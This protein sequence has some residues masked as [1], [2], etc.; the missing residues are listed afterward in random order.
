VRR[1]DKV[2]VF[3]VLVLLA[4]GCANDDE[5]GEQG[6]SSTS[7][8][9]TAVVAVAGPP[10]LEDRECDPDQVA[11]VPA[12]VVVECSW[13]VVPARRDDPGAGEFRLAVSVLRS[14][15]DA[16]APDPVVYVSG[17]PGMPGG[18]PLSWA[19]R[20]WVQERDVVL[21]DQRGTGASEPDLEC[22]EAEPVY[23]EFFT[24]DR[25]YDEDAAALREALVACRDRLVA[26]GIDLAVFNTPES[27]ADLADLRVALGYDEWNLYGV[28]YGSR[29][30]LEVMRSHPEGIRSV[31]LD[32][33][34][35]MGNGTVTWTVESTEHAFGQ[36]AAGCAADP[37]CAAE[38]EDLRAELDAVVERYNETPHRSVVDLG[39]NDGGPT[40]IVIT[41][42]DIQA[43]MYEAIFGNQLIP[44]LPS[45]ITALN[46][47]E[48][49]LLDQ[50]AVQSIPAQGQGAEAMRY[51]T[52]CADTAPLREADS[53]ADSEVLEQPGS[54]ST[55]IL[56]V[57]WAFCD[58]W[59]AGAVDDSFLDP[60]DADLPVLVL[61]GTYDPAT[62][63]SG[64]REVAEALPRATLV[65]FEG[66]GHGLFRHSEC[67]VD[68]AVSFVDDPAATL[69][70]TCADEAGPPAF[71]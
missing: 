11:D 2:C 38:H 39:P 60:V 14:T 53:A 31:V 13:L 65:T 30:S 19:E 45:A 61:A 29:L 52:D 32:S 57:S 36:L 56:F 70:T 1:V 55:F 64:A 20:P 44:I 58:V 26:A 50:I 62:P 5:P 51:S 27:A 35:P 7:S 34:Y 46:A 68:V 15:A 69:D 25:S 48:S 22:P 66:F 40:E 47:G 3:I 54:W 63:L 59:T 67:A 12:E 10:G 28:S 18:D 21:F 71:G 41:G 17:G 24:T 16:P 9:T 8:S 4:A 49:G 42:D 6:R 37:A 43:G 23:R 33:T